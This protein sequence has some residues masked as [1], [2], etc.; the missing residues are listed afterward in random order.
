M[1]NKHKIFITILSFLIL[2]VSESFTQTA[3]GDLHYVSATFNTP[4]SIY[5]TD[6]DGDGNNDII[7]GSSTDSIV[8]FRNTGA[9]H[10]TNAICITTELD[11]IRVVSGCDIDKDGDIDVLSG[12]R[13][14]STI[15]WMENT[16]IGNFDA[17]KI[18]ATDSDLVRFVGG[19]DMDNDNDIDIVACYV[20]RIVWYIND[21]NCNFSNAQVISTG[22]SLNIC[23]AD[24]N[25]DEYPDVFTTNL[26]DDSLLWLKNEGNGVFSNKYIPVSSGT[27]KCNDIDVADINSNGK[28]D[29]IVSS[30]V[31]DY[32]GKISWFE[33][34]G[35]ETITYKKRVAL[36][37]EEFERI[38]A[39]D[40][41][42]DCNG[43]IFATHEHDHSLF[44]FEK[45]DPFFD[46]EEIPYSLMEV[47]DLILGDM[48]MDGD[49]DVI[50]S[51]IFGPDITW[52]ENLTLEVLVQPNDVLFCPLE[53]ILFSTK[54]KDA[55]SYTWQVRR[56][57]ATYFS[58]IDED[59]DIYWGANTDELQIDKP[60]ISLD[61][62][63]YRCM[64]SNGEG[65]IYSDT[66]T[67]TMY[68]DE[69]PPY[70][71]LKNSVLY[72]SPSPVTKLIVDTVID[73]ISDNCNHIDVGVNADI[74]SCANLGENY[75]I[76][77][78][79]DG[80]SNTVTKTTLVVVIDTLAPTIQIAHSEIEI[81]SSNSSYI[82]ETEYCPLSLYYDN[83][84]IV[85]ISNNISNGESLFGVELKLGSTDVIWT[86][87][88]NS[89]NSSQVTQKITLTNTN[90]YRVYPNP[91]NSYFTI[92]QKLLGEYEIK[93]FDVAG[94]QVFQSDK[95]F[96]VSY[97]VNCSFLTR[98]TYIVQLNNGL[99]SLDYKLIISK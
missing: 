10:F 20:Y 95:I 21:G 51:S 92:E 79:T 50:I 43:D 73:S 98:G 8:W 49:K 70:L 44:R 18:I 42:S 66:V 58:T 63:Q 62:F 27:D 81:F 68:V 37:Y 30:L 46:T 13:Y 33:Y 80:S 71:K 39:G 22:Y 41:S 89:G 28:M 75:I 48:D 3:I 29:I 5:A 97:H 93:I 12:S 34:D 59:D 86:V 88:D 11:N 60:T 72:L 96:D 82:F 19:Y 4:F 54:I 87:T 69:E 55:I 83:C 15:A 38:V 57:G 94:R 7:A 74:F 9:G 16:G 40:L 35:N 17:P 64:G 90:E 65:N 32:Y 85:S 1:D 45:N 56:S 2:I 23:I 78:A 84:E 76:V 67:L 6:I 31:D 47:G 61:N 52:F 36:K 26:S 99:Q 14:D 91:A 53:P 25:G 77:S 24:I